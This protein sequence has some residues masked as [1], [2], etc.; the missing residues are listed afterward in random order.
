[1]TVNDERR[2]F[3]TRIAKGYDDC[4]VNAIGYTAYKTLPER[5]L[6]LH[7]GAKTVLDL[8][9][10]TGL[11]SE[12][13]FAQGLE[14]IGIDYSPGMIE[15]ARKRPYKELHCQ[16]IDDVLPVADDSFDLAI[17]IGVTEFIE[18]PKA[19]LQSVWHKLSESGL[20]ALTL[21]VPSENSSTLNIKDYTLESFMALVN[22][23][24]FILA[25]SFELYG[26][27]S[28]YLAAID[29]EP[30]GVHLLVNYTAVFLRKQPDKMKRTTCSEIS[31]PKSVEAS[32][33]D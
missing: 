16:R 4:V 29:G 19:L 10:G 25:D 9:C 30:S 1:M 14:V 22:P 32:A 13:F 33:P 20:F 6:E 3:F 17:A 7:P 24:E 18:N 12:A 28:G 26:W 31:R 5:A 23:K 27:K 15:V 8:A 2:D 21:P 11:S